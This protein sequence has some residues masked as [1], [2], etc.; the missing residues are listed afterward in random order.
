MKLNLI[1]AVIAQVPWPTPVG[2][3]AFL[4]TAHLKAVPLSI[5]CALAAFLVYLL[6]I[7][8]YDKQLLEEEGTEV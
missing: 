4:G 5:V 6:F 1:G 7:R 2:I 8:C 3:G